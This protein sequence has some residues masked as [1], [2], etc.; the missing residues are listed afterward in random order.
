MKPW[1]VAVAALLGVFANAQDQSSCPG[2]RQRVPTSN[3]SSGDVKRNITVYVAA[4]EAGDGGTSGT[5]APAGSGGY[6][7]VGSRVSPETMADTV[8][9]VEQHQYRACDI[10]L[11]II[12]RVRESFQHLGYFCADVEPIAAQQTGKNEY[13][14]TIHV[15]PGEQYRV[16]EIK[17][18]GATLLS[19]DELTSALHLKSNSLFNTESIRRGLD[20]IQKSYAKKGHANVTAIPV[21]SVDEKDRKITLAIKIHES[22]ATQ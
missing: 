4:L 22:S 15:H 12:E 20:N 9:H 1:I 5:Y 17:F 13:K 2:P 6:A 21:A 16:G 3:C 19:A 14:I 7:S 10:G 11:E 18:T 8:A